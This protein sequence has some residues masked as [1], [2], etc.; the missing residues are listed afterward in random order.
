MENG[1]WG[2]LR[3]VSNT[4]RDHD[5]RLRTVEQFEEHVQNE[6]AR[7]EKLIDSKLKDGGSREKQPMVHRRGVAD[8]PKLTGDASLSLHS[9]FLMT[10]K[11]FFI[12]LFRM[13][14]L[15]DFYHFFLSLFALAFLFAM[16]LIYFVYFWILLGYF[17]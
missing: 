12:W 11:P 13:I 8:I 2:G 1:K 14:F 6:V 9:D 17:F 3:G 4:I 16:L 5:R 10:F 7:I 15:D